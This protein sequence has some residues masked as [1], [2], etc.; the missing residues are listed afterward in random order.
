MASLTEHVD[1]DGLREGVEAGER[2]AA[3][4]AERLRLVEDGGD[5]ALLGQ[6]WEG[7]AEP[8]HVLGIKVDPFHSLLQRSARLARVDPVVC[9]TGVE[10]LLAWS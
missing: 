3:F 5:A 1:E 4:G 9:E 7:D 10:T 8:R 2:V 6:G